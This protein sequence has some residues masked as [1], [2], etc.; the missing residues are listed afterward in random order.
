MITGL[1]RLSGFVLFCPWICHMDFTNWFGLW[2]SLASP[3]LH[4]ANEQG[5]KAKLS[6]RLF[7]NPISAID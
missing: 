7:S 2:H 6:L 4:I 1:K 3:F 5:Q